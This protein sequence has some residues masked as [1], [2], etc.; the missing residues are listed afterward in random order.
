MFGEI[1]TTNKSIQLSRV[2]IKAHKLC[3]IINETSL[4]QV[5]KQNI[6]S[7]HKSDGRKIKK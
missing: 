3:N 4:R 1:T 6:E 2:N 5:A 7:R